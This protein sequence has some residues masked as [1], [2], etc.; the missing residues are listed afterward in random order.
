M[1]TSLYVGVVLFVVVLVASV[2]SVE[3]G[4]SVAIIEIVLGVVV[5]NTLHLSTP[6]WLTFL[7][8]FGSVVLTFLAGAEVD[9][10]TFRSSLKA[11][12]NPWSAAA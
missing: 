1:T 4:L 7:A 3:L 12:R 10:D 11:R 5:G 9:P 6:D 8:G 2:V